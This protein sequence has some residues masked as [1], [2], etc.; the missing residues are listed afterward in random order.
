[1]QQYKFLTPSSLYHLYLVSLSPTT[2]GAFFF[3][4]PDLQHRLLAVVLLK[5]LWRRFAR[6]GIV[7]DCLSKRCFSAVEV[8]FL[9]CCSFDSGS[10]SEG[11]VYLKLRMWKVQLYLLEHVLGLKL[12]LL[13]ILL[14]GQLQSFLHF[15]LKHS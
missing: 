9:V 8:L 6:S 5:E 7:S 14:W 11:L 13:A 12:M 3:L 1:M 15:G 4:L 10:C 2:I